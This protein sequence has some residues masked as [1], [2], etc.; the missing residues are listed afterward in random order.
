MIE[1]ESYIE[2]KEREDEQQLERYIF[3]Q[4]KD[5]IVDKIGERQWDRLWRDYSKGHVSLDSRA[6]MRRL[7]AYFNELGLTRQDFINGYRR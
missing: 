4:V 6:S 1:D 3:Q 5:I 2:E 7:K